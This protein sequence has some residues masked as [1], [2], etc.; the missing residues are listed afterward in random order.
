[1]KN[2]YDELEISK[3]ASKEVIEKVY[4]TLAK[5]YHPDTTTEIDKQAAEEK[6]KAISE[7]YEILSNDEK[8]K[9]FDLELDKSNQTISYE[10]YINVVNQRD[11]LNNAFNNL[12]N[13][14][15]QY[16][17]SGQS[18]YNNKNS[19]YKNNTVHNQNTTNTSTTTNPKSK[20]KKFKYYN[21]ATGKPVSAISYYIY[22][23]RKFF[24]DV[25]IFLLATLA[26][27][28]M[29]NALFNIGFLNI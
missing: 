7:A 16:K 8:R 15:N 23:I 5:K 21:V 25:G 12:K 19:S 11:S 24:S 14:F 1:M 17:N 10:E 4:K 2:Y 13:E 29:I 22:R 6:F 9:K 26:F 18:N 28:L 27:I 20:S 3:N